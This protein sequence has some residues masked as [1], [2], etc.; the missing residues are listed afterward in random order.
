M[1]CVILDW[2]LDQEKIV[3]KDLLRQLI[4]FEYGPWIRK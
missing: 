3:I 4:K 2:I 1:Q